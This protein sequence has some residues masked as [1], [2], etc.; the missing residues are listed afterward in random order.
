M[1][2]IQT[3]RQLAYVISAVLTLLA[4][5]FI[6]LWYY[7]DT[8][9]IWMLAFLVVFMTASFV[10]LQILLRKYISEKIKPVYK[11]ILDKPSLPKT[12]NPRKNI[13]I[14]SEVKTDVEEWAEKQTREIERL[15]ELEKYRKEF[16]GN[17]SHELKTPI[18]NIQGYILT[19]LEGGI[20]DPNINKLYLQRTETSINRLIS[21]VED[22]EAITKLESGELKLKPEKF[23][24]VKLVE[25]FFN[26]A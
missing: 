21:V 23:D 22:L 11:T 10:I 25:E 18:F 6:L 24:L 7:I 20:D 1:I 9:L 4:G 2:P 13:N 15:K 12:G 17:V 3:S 19:L 14:L 26:S 5:F 8:S 16:V